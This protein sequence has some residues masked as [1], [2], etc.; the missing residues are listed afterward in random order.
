METALLEQARAI[1]A[2]VAAGDPCGGDERVDCHAVRA[3]AELLIARYRREV[4]TFQ[5]EVCLREDIA[6]GLMVSGRSLLV[7]TETRMSRGRLDA[8]LQHEVSVHVLTFVNGSQQGLGIFGSGLAGY[9]GL[10]SEEHTS[11][12]QSL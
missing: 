12:L 8:L 1:L 6:P 11:E 7:S 10:R 3:A 5:A 2:Q 4:P 9:E